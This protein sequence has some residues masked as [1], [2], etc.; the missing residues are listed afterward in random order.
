MTDTGSAAQAE[1]ALP[2]LAVGDVNKS[3]PGVQALRNVS[4]DCL[5]GEV[6]GLVGENGAG[7][8]T[9]MRILAGAMPPDSGFIRLRGEGVVLRSPRHAHDF[10]V[11]MVYQ[12]TRLVDD[13]DVAQNILL[14]REPGALLLID[15][16]A[17]EGRARSILRRLG[18]PLDLRRPVRDLSTAE[19][20]IVEIG[21]VLATDPSVLILD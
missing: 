4:F 3:F 21:R 6:H 7:K 5:S 11:A 13:L 8:S 15:R 19:R 20:Q 9:L 12:D 16:R 10:G 17:L 2:A 1:E 14:G 18:F